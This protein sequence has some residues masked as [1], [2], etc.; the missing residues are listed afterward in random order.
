[1]E[2]TSY[3]LSIALDI[4]RAFDTGWWPMILLNSKDYRQTSRK[5]EEDV[6][7][8]LRLFYSSRRRSQGC[9]QS[10]KTTLGE[11]KPNETYLS[12]SEALRGLAAI[13]CL[14]LEAR[15][16]AEV[17]SGVAEMDDPDVEGCSRVCAFTPHRIGVVATGKGTFGVR[18]CN[19][20]KCESLDGLGLFRSRLVPVE[21][22]RHVTVEDCGGK[23]LWEV[24]TESTGQS[25]VGVTILWQLLSE[26]LRGR[27]DCS[28]ALGYHSIFIRSCIN[29]FFFLLQFPNFKLSKHS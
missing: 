22:Q 28:A 14:Q 17:L 3:L 11:E 5:Q 24:S 8:V 10:N 1:M 9:T 29:G 15:W 4:H 20:P 16:H 27:M 23:S 12:G 6:W 21:I 13:W 2:N 25:F 18:A 26:I 7:K 19:S